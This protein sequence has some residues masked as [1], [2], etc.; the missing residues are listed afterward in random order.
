[1]SYPKFNRNLQSVDKRGQ[2]CPWLTCITVLA[3]TGL[4]GNAYGLHKQTNGIMFG[5]RREIS[6][7]AACRIDPSDGICLFRMVMVRSPEGEGVVYARDQL[8]GNVSW[9]RTALDKRLNILLKSRSG[10]DGLL[11]PVGKKIKTIDFVRVVR[12][13]RIITAIS[14]KLGFS[15]HR[16]RRDQFQCGSHILSWRMAV[17]RNAYFNWKQGR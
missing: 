4:V 10:L 14:F 6:H 7:G 9:F 3:V 5:I 13:L 1:M 11:V 8:K 2:L 17:V 15:W 12:F 16:Q